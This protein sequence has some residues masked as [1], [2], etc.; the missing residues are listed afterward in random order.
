MPKRDVPDAPT[1]PIRNPEQF[2][3]AVLLGFMVP[4]AAIIGLVM[5]VVSAEKTA[6]GVS[7][8]DALKALEARIKPIAW[9]AIEYRSR[10]PMTGEQVYQARCIG[11]HSALGNARVWAPRI[12]RGFEALLQS[13]L[14]GKGAMPPRAGGGFEDVEIGRALVYMANAAGGKLVVPDRLEKA[15]R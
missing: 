6:P 1:G 4:V 12:A 7:D 11:C 2:L 13:V 5:L 9:S 3:L 8:A 15:P 10:P 14:N